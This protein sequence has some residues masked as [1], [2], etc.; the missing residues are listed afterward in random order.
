MPNPKEAERLARAVLLCVDVER[1]RPDMEASDVLDLLLSP[2]LEALSK[3][4]TNVYLPVRK[5]DKSLQLVL[6]LFQLGRA[7]DCQPAGEEQG[8]SFYP[9]DLALPTQVK[10]YIKQTLH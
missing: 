7:S 9:W 4:G 6:R 5:S 3:I 10:S 1:T 2:L 8:L